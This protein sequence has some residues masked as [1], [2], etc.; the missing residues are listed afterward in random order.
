MEES[1]RNSTAFTAGNFQYRWVRMPMG[2]ASSQ[3][4]WQ[5]AINTILA[6]LIGKGVYVY[7]DDIIIY[8]KTRFIH[9]DL[10]HK[11]MTLLQENNLQLK[12][13]KCVFYAKNFNI[14]VT[15]S[16]R[17]ASKPT[18][19]KLKLLKIIQDHKT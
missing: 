19:R 18:Q 5:R 7:L 17:R 13:S 12:I 3:L 11:V 8:A 2:L 6:E 16:P 9:N 10:V 1:S 4:T 14:W 15:S